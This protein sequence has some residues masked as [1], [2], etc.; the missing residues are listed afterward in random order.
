MPE[1]HL[2]G[3]FNNHCI[4]R[5]SPHI[6]ESNIAVEK[7]YKHKQKRKHCPQNFKRS[8]A[9]N[10]L[11]WLWVVLFTVAYDKIYHR[12]GNSDQKERRNYTYK[13][14]RI[15]NQFYYWVHFIT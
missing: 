6:A 11:V 4:G 14:K 12:D 10:C 8:V 5:N 3:D 1:P 13:Y 7:H 2:P 9:G 15:V